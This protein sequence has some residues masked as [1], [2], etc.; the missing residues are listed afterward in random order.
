M[1]GDGVLA[2]IG[3]EIVELNDWFLI[4]RTYTSAAQ[5]DNRRDDPGE[6]VAALKARPEDTTQWQ[7]DALSRI[8]ARACE[9]SRSHQ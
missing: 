4:C 2:E 3:V 5:V 8:E 1:D 9:S 6:T 7:L